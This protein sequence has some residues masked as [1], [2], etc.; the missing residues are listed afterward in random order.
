MEEQEQIVRRAKV[1]GNGAHVFVPKEWAGEEI[2]VLRPIKKDVRERAFN[3]LN[4]YFDKII[5][6][7]LYGSYARGENKADS[8]VDLLV[9]TSEKIKIKEKG[10]SILCIEEKD[11]EESVKLEPLLMYSILSEAKSII[12][13]ALLERLKTE[14]RAK[15]SDFA[16]FISSTKK[17]IKINKEFLDS[18]KDYASEAVIY[19]L[20]LRLRGVFIIKKLIKGEKYS[21]KEFKHWIKSNVKIDFDLIYELYRK[22][23]MEMKIKEKVKK[24]DALLLIEFLREQIEA[25]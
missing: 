24:K 25:L 14:Y 19:S 11:I 17:F 10:F 1:F 4:D 22:S 8:D 15:K 2:I 20:V 23:K 6:V 9:I 12:N 16:E 18:E 3:V 21:H 13:E 5:G 7:Y